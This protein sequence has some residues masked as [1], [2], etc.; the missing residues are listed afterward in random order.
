MDDARGMSSS[1]RIGQLLHQASGLSRRQGGAAQSFGQRAAATVLQGK[2]R[3]ALPGPAVENL[4]DVYMMQAS[5]GLC[6][7]LE[8]SSLVLI[9]VVSR[10]NHLEGHD[11]AQRQVSCLVDDAHAATAQLSQDL[12]TWEALTIGAGQ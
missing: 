3:L 12:V 5:D 7:G 4:D 10:T 9:G 1:D 2:V 6:F 8:S 11:P